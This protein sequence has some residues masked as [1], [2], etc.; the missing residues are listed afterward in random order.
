[1]L[2]AALFVV[3]CN[4][5]AESPEAPP[6]TSEATEPEAVSESAPAPSDGGEPPS[7]WDVAPEEGAP[8]APGDEG[9]VEAAEG[10]AEAAGMA[11]HGA[12]EAYFATDDPEAWWPEFSQHLTPAAQ[13]VWQ[14]TDPRRVP[15]GAPKGSAEY[16][17]VSATDAEVT[18]PTTIGDFQLVMVRAEA[19]DPWKVSYMEP[20]EEAG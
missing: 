17:P 20:P 10:D 14:Y 6:S 9:P 1:M 15:S 16:G 13:E 7:E 11:A 4:G 12:V 3:G 5:P 19:G 8:I 18:V 2:A